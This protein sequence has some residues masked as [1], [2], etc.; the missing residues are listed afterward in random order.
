MLDGYQS[1]GERYEECCNAKI[2]GCKL[3]DVGQ[4]Y[5]GAEGGSISPEDTWGLSELQAKLGDGWK[6]EK[7]CLETLA[8]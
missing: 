5:R 3:D 4:R 1:N 2:F 6:E 7:I 8:L